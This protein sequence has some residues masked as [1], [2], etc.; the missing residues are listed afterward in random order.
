MKKFAAVCIGVGLMFALTGCGND[1]KLD[2]EENDLVAEYIAGVMLKHSYENQWEYEK[3]DALKKQNNAAG[4][5]NSSGNSNVSP[6]QSAGN[7]NTTPTQNA[8]ASNTTP[9][10][11]PTT[12]PKPVETQPSNVSDSNAVM[13][14][15]KEALGLNMTDVSYTAVLSGLR[16]PEGEYVVSVPANDSCVLVAVEFE[17]K[18][19]TAVDI[20][21]D[22]SSSKVTMKLGMEGTMFS[23]SVTIL[24]NDITRLKQVK[25]GAGQTYT[26]C[27]VFQVPETYSDSLEGATL[28]IYNSGN[29]IGTMKL[30]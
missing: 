22:T 30:K 15:M 2:S 4:D 29:A 7:S 9:T 13:N 8:G 12:T 11:A 27:A 16:Y 18:N 25:I 6:T 26:A 3:L 21:A 14:S 23:K 5:K 10:N 1:V 28:T 20:V 17:I 19:P 24:K